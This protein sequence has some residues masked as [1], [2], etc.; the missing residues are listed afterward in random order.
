MDGVAFE[1]KQFPEFHIRKDPETVYARFIKYAE[2]FKHNH[3]KAYSITDKTQQWSL[4]LD[5]IG[6]FEQLQSTGTDLDGAIAALKTKFKES[7]NQLYNIHKFRCITKQGKDEPWESFIAKL[8]AEGRH[9]EFPDNWLDTEILMAMIKNGKSK[10]ARRKLL[11]DRLTVEEAIKFQTRDE[12]R[13]H[14][15]RH[16]NKA[17]NRQSLQ[18]TTTTRQPAS[19]LQNDGHTLGDPK[20]ARYLENSAWSVE[21]KTTLRNAAEANTQLEPLG[22]S[23]TKRHGNLTRRP[24]AVM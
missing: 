23:R 10:K 1:L 17:R 14:A 15:T 20:N 3:L 13:K 16:R 19:I 12:G 8:R 5:S 7:Q 4:F 6:V 18:P 9:C 21:R 22:S 2:R 24:T 11:Q